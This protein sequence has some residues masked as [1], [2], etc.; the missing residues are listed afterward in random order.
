MKVRTTINPDL[1]VEVDDGELLDL[2]RSGLL[3]DD[4]PAPAPV[5]AVNTQKEGT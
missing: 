4:S 3:L 2:R 5:A 1:E